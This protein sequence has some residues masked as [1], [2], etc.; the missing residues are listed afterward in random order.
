MAI[1]VS[2]VSA[3][4]YFSFKN[5]WKLINSRLLVGIV[6]DRD[7]DFEKNYQKP[8]L[9]LFLFSFYQTW[10]LYNNCLMHLSF[11]FQHVHFGLLLLKSM[12]FSTK[13]VIFGCIY[14]ILHLMWINT[15]LVLSEKAF[16]SSQKVMKTS[17]SFTSLKIYKFCKI[18]TKMFFRNVTSIYFFM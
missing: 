14:Y 10:G 4:V 9:R 7:M 18:Q 15:S 16:L 8:F 5:W 3:N 2:D 12:K 1:L 11:A 13:T 6:W 17:F